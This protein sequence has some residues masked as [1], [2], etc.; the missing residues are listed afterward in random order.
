MRTGV[1]KRLGDVG[2][3]LEN[4]QDPAWFMAGM[5]MRAQECFLGA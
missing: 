1:R 2:R 3:G 5:E 4:V